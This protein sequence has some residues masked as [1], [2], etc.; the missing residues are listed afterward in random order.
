MEFATVYVLINESLTK[1]FSP[2]KGLRQGDPLAQFLFLIAA[3][4]LVGVSR[5][6]GEIGFLE[7]LEVG[8]KKVRV[9][10]LQYADDTLFFCQ[11]NIK[12][13][14]TIKVILSYFE[15]AYGLKV[16]FLK[17]S[18]EGV[19]IDLFMIW[20]F[21]SILNCDVMNTPFKYLGMSVGGVMREKL[22]GMVCFGI[23]FASPG[24]S[25][26]LVK[27]TSSFLIWPC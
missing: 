21:A 9:N 26:G 20:G 10:M 3:E 5:N 27:L 22:L 23:R 18:I 1:K 15:L 16:N 24:K 14:F 13:V 6:A 11:T 2:L 25:M 4:G 12:S 7:S 17:S 8:S 19:G